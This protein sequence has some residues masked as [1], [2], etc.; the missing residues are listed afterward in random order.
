[1]GTSTQALPKLGEAFQGGKFA[2]ITT[3]KQGNVYALISLDDK[4]STALNWQDAMAW[5]KGLGNGAT[6]PN[7]VESAML[8]ANLQGEF[9]KDWCWTCESFDSYWAW[10]QYFSYGLQHGNRKYDELRARAVRRLP[11][12][13]LVI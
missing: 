10:Y 9:Y 4:P 7:C 13:S 6:L 5:A 2:G 11:I 3:D 1:M 12:Q 8:F